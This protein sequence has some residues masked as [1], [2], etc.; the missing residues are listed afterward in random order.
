MLVELQLR[1]RLLRFGR[2]ALV[3]AGEYTSGRNV[4]SRPVAI[5]PR[6]ENPQ[7][8]RARMRELKWIAVWHVCGYGHKEGPLMNPPGDKWL[9]KLSKLRVDRA[10]GDPAPHKPLLIL[11]V[12]DLAQ[13]GLLPPRTLPLTP[14][15]AS[16]FLSYSSVVAKRRSQRPDVRYPFHHLGGDGIWTPVDENFEP[17]ADRKLTRCAELPSDFIHFV[18][19]PICRDKACHLLIAKYFRPSERIAL[20][21]LIGLPRPSEIEIEENAAFK[22]A[23]DAMLVGREA[24]FRIKILA[25]YDYTCALTGYRL[26][27]LASGSIVDAAHIHQFADSRNNE[28]GNGLALSKNAHWSFDQGLW[29]ISDDFRVLVDSRKF[30]ESSDRPDLLLGRYHG[31][32]LQLP[33]DRG[34]WPNLVHIAWHRKNR[35]ERD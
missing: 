26:T 32:R 29:T 17:S 10:S 13:E 7:S 25:A 19:D 22:S 28:L 4:G 9:N 34:L 27:T 24:R 18:S 15:L 35:F 33:D 14:E 21:E 3:T 2:S 8:I 20:Y 6:W 12:L 11:V 30:A 5:T 31:L 23:E 16:R 1:K